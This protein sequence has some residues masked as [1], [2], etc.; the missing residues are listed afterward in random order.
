MREASNGATL[1]WGP[2]IADLITVELHNSSDYEV[3]EY[4]A[5]S[6]ELSTSGQASVSF[7]LALGGSYY[8]TIKHRNSIETTTATPVSLASGL[9]NYN[10]DGPSKAYGWNLHPEPDGKYVIFTEM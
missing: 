4:T 2:G 6:V 10:F 7:P 9:V 5:D 1:Q 8:I 3:V